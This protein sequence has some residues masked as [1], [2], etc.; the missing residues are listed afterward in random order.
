[1][2]YVVFNQ[3]G[4]IGKSSIAVN[5]S[6]TSAKSG[7][8]SLLIDWDAQSNSTH[9]IGSEKFGRVLGVRD[10]FQSQLSPYSCESI[11]GLIHQS[12]YSNLS[13]LPFGF[14]LFELEYRFKSRYEILKLNEALAELITD[15]DRIYLDTPPAFFLDRQRLLPTGWLCPLTAIHFRSKRCINRPRRAKKLKQ[16]T[17]RNWCMKRL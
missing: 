14:G 15:F 11:T 13:F 10:F 16:I 8:K 7:L 3:K 12:V 5:L 17:P 6:A 9:Y 1:M 4:G 2:L